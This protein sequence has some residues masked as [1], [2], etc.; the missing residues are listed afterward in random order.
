MPRL[1]RGF[2]V[3]SCLSGKEDRLSERTNYR[4]PCVK[5]ADAVGG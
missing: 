5:G 3:V 2:A 4:L 1:A